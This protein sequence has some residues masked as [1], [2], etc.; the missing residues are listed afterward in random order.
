MLTTADDRCGIGSY[1][2]VLVEA[3]RALPDTH[4]DVVRIQAGEQSAT[5]QHEGC[6]F[7]EL[8]ANE[9]LAAAAAA[10]KANG[11]KRDVLQLR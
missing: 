3:L 5:Q 6:V 10:I 2:A 11:T 9:D 7:S 4:V 1:S 8:S